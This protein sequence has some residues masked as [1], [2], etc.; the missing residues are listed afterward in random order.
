MKQ[1]LIFVL[2]VP[3]ITLFAQVERWTVKSITD[4][5]ACYCIDLTQVSS[6]SVSYLQKRS[7][8]K[9]GDQEPRL[10]KECKIIEVTGFVLRKDLE[11]DGDYHIEIGKN[12]QQD[13]GRLVCESKDPENAT[14]KKSLYYTLIR[15]VRS[16]V[17]TLQ[18]GSKVRLQGVQFQDQKHGQLGK[19][20]ANYLEI[21]PIL[22][23]LKP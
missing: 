20:I 5:P 7:R 11:E 13:T 19:R 21:H 3:S 18:V 8:T 1:L 12:M 16:I 17:D 23:I 15:N 22:Y 2:F 14:V 10:P 9:V 4:T 6:R